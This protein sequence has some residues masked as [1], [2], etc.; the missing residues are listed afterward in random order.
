MERKDWDSRNFNCVYKKAQS[1]Y[2]LL[3]KYVSLPESIDFDGDNT[4][5]ASGAVWP[6]RDLCLRIGVSNGVAKFS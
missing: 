3:E 5:V 2:Q 4:G 6:L 1:N